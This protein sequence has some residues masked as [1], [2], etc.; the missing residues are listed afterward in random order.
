MAAIE[1]LLILRPTPNGMV[2]VMEGL[3]IGPPTPLRS[4]LGSQGIPLAVLNRVLVA[5]K[6]IIARGKDLDYRGTPEDT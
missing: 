2:G 3:V 1:A 6:E 4:T 5:I